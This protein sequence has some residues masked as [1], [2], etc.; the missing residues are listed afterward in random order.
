[1]QLDFESIIDAVRDC[2]PA[3]LPGLIGALEQAKAEAW[4]A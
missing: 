4:G 2:D 3:S 1:M